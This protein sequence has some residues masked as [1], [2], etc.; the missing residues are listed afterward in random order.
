MRS[1]L[2]TAL[3]AFVLCMQSAMA[4]TFPGEPHLPLS[5]VIPGVGVNVG[6]NLSPGSNGNGAEILSGSRLESINCGIDLIQHAQVVLTSAQ[7]KAL[8]STPITIVPATAGKTTVVLGVLYM[9]TFG[10]TDYTSGGTVTLQYHTGPVAITTG[11]ANTFF[12]GGATAYTT[13]S[14]IPA[15]AVQNNAVE[16]T[17]ASGNFA[18]GDS[19]VT[20][21]VSYA[22]F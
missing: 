12:Q 7:I 10:T 5:K 6:V 18:T 8:H 19:T 22:Q 2:V 3:L 1:K 11:I 13:D 14:T 20:V 17:A 16:V 9:L 4:S 15:L 21:D